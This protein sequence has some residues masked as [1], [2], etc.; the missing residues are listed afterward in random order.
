MVEYRMK[1]K[2]LVCLNC[3]EKNLRGPF[4]LYDANLQIDWK[5]YL[6]PVA[7]V[8]MECGHTMFF[9]EENERKK[10]LLEEKIG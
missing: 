10:I 5:S 9:A 1:M 8:C 7:L 6:K 3:G 4:K 2:A